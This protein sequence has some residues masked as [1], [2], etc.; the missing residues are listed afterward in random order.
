MKLYIQNIRRH[1]LH[2]KGATPWL[3]SYTNEFGI[4]SIVLKTP[5]IRAEIYW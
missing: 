4:R 1:P 5:I 2:F 3:W